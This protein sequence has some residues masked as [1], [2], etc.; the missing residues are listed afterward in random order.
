MTRAEALAFVDRVYAD[1]RRAALTLLLAGQG[2]PEPD[3][4]DDIFADFDAEYEET[5]AR[6]VAWL[7]ALPA[8]A[9][10]AAR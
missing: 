8:G 4:I 10:V 5:R 3:A 2:E 9:V 1:R 7:D 6:L